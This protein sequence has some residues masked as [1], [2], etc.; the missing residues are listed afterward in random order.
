MVGPIGQAAGSYEVRSR[1]ATIWEAHR[2]N[3]K[4]DHVFLAGHDMRE[5]WGFVP[6]NCDPAQGVCREFLHELGAKWR[7]PIC[8]NA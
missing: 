6:K 4:R 8:A 3:N 1:S 2:I 7:L 5:E